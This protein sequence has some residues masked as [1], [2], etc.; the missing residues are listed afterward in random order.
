[1]SKRL[2]QRLTIAFASLALL[3]S[4]CGPSEDE[5]KSEVSTRLAANQ[6]TSRLGLSVSV[7]KRTITL[8]GKTASKE[9]QQ[10]AVDLARSVDRVQNVVN[11]MWI[12]NTALA[13][14]V[15]A[16]LG[17]D[18]LVG[19]LGIDV[20]ARGNTVRLWSDQTNREERVRAVEVASAVE[21]VGQVEDR[22]K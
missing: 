22:M 4:A 2:H 19:K 17:S 9:E 5:L 20:D 18:P 3:C 8:S 14:K 16:A 10:V 12:N 13:D 15:K 11:D 7:N 1:V 21:G 6:T